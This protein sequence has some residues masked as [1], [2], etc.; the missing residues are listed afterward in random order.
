[1][2]CQHC[3]DPTGTCD[4]ARQHCADVS[5]AIEEGSKGSWGTLGLFPP[6]EPDTLHKELTA[7]IVRLEVRIRLWEAV[8]FAV[9]QQLG[10]TRELPDDLLRAAVGAG[11]TLIHEP[12]KTPIEDIYAAFRRAILAAE[13]RGVAHVG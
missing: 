2:T 11:E 10:M 3:D 4:H 5:G 9:L 6:R 1:M 8:G 13:L 12:G 7:E